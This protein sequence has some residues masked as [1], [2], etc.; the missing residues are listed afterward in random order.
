MDREQQIAKWTAAGYARAH[1]ERLIDRAGS[2]VYPTSPI[3]VVPHAP[4]GGFAVPQRA[5]E[6]A[7]PSLAIGQKIQV[8][9]LDSAILGHKD[10]PM[11]HGVLHWVYA[12]VL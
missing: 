7:Q 3:A 2:G 10:N 8:K 4:G 11:S 6:P 9:Q 1:A 5:V 12:T